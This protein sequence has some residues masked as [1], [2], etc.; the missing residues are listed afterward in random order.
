MKE[1]NQPSPWQ[2]WSMEVQKKLHS[3]Q[4]QIHRLEKLLADLFGKLKELE[5]KPTY[6]IEKIE[7]QFDQLKV[8]KLD[9]TLNIGMT[10]PG[11]DDTLTPGNIEQLAVNKHFPSASHSIVANDDS[12]YSKIHEKMV[13]YLDSANA[14]NGMDAVQE[15]ASSNDFALQLD[16]QHRRMV[17]EDLKKQLPERIRYYLQQLK[18][19]DQ[20]QS[21]LYPDLLVS[22]VFEKTRRD[23]DAAL[24]AY[25]RQ[26][27]SQSETTGGSHDSI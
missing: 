15:A 1:P 25:I 9:G 17:M 11:N 22:R 24:Q 2:L 21:S 13:Q 18:K 5:S 20:S 3:Q 6:N 8:E 14:E 26:L 16:P 7:Y 4:E 23:A 10:A 19:E 27:Q 12:N